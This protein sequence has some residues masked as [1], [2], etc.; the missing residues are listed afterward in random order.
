MWRGSYLWVCPESDNRLFQPSGR[1]RTYRPSQPCSGYLPP[2]C[3]GRAG[4][5]PDSRR[6]RRGIAYSNSNAL[7][8]ISRTY[9]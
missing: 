5:I 3:P 4:R 1:S 2:R 9:S 8:I 6:S 7:C